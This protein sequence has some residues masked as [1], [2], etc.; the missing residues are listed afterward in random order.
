MVCQD[1][2]KY[3]ERKF[4]SHFWSSKEIQTLKETIITLNETNEKLRKDLEIKNKRI[5]KLIFLLKGTKPT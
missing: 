3:K 2:K 1:C 4:L 5:I